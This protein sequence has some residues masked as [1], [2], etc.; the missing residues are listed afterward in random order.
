MIG[1]DLEMRARP[2]GCRARRQRRTGSLEHTPGRTD[3]LF[4]GRSVHIVVISFDSYGR[5]FWVTSRL[6]NVDSVLGVTTSSKPA[7]T[8]RPTRFDYVSS[9]YNFRTPYH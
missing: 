5:A 8:H 2:S 7:L 9:A 6:W 3:G 1:R 4:L